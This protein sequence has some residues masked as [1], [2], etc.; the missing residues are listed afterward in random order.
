M[1]NSKRTDFQTLPLQRNKSLK[2]VHGR[3]VDTSRLY[4]TVILEKEN[5]FTW[6]KANLKC[7]T[8]N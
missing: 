5:H 1:A 8:K 6:M 3:D 2:S 4:L 7:K